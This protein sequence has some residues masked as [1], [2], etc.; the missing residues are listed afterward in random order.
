MSPSA[1]IRPALRLGLAVSLT[2]AA[3]YTALLWAATRGQ[4]GFADGYDGVGFVLAVRDFD[5][6][7]FQPHPPGFPLFVLLSRGLHAVVPSSPSLAVAL[8]GALILPLG[9]GATAA[10]VSAWAGHFAALLFALLAG[11]NVLVFG[12]GVATLSDGAGLGMALLAISGAICSL[13][14]SS[15]GIGRV[16]GLLCGVALGVRP[17]SLTILGLALGAACGLARQQRRPVQGPLLAMLLS[18]T[19]AT[20]AWLLPLGFLVGPQRLITLCLAHAHGHFTDFGG[21]MLGAGHDPAAR[22]RSLIH[23][24]WTLLAVLGLP[25]CAVALIALAWLYRARRSQAANRYLPSALAVAVSIAYLA[26][27]LVA[28]R[29]S[30]SGRHLLPLPVGLAFATAPLVAAAV[31]RFAARSFLIGTVLFM[32]VWNARAVFAFRQSPA[33]GA[34]L[35]SSLPSCQ[36]P[37]YGARAARYIDL[38]CGSG[39]AQPALY[40]GEVLSDLERRSNPPHEVLV[41]SE[42]L[43]SSASQARLRTLGRYCINADVP[44]ILRFDA[45]SVP[46]HHL[47]PAAI[48]LGCVELLAYRVLP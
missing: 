35:A 42:V 7:R 23:T 3:L 26:Y 29:T 12:L 17:Q 27:A 43:A 11:T 40:L 2:L 37:V 41:T 28:T 9:I 19:L 34:Q 22:A 39:S 25:L 18:T 44:A 8:V 46:A 24:A 47:G 6:A 36:V 15:I 10:V 20:F 32:A 33:P 45:G 48:G 31:P 16:A 38:I 13:Q 30:G 5:L 1:D 21:S 14:R 4:S